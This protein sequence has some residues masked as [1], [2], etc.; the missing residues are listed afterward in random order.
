[1]DKFN[2]TYTALRTA[3]DSPS[4][5]ST[6]VILNCLTV[7]PSTDKMPVSLFYFSQLDCGK[8]VS[9][10]GYIVCSRFF[11]F[12]RPF[13]LVRT[14]TPIDALM[15]QVGIEPTTKKLI[16]YTSSP[17]EALP[18]ELLSHFISALYHIFSIC[19]MFFY[20]LRVYSIYAHNLL[21]HLFCVSILESVMFIR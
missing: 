18:P 4:L 2:I 17:V 6:S 11:F 21:C 16:L 7:Y 10:A 3:P 5:P 19:Q 12:V 8:L 15:R 20:F 1:M 9:N 14:E 13:R